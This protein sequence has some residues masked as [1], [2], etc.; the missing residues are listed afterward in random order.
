LFTKAISDG[1]SIFLPR[2]KE[3]V[4]ILMFPGKDGNWRVFTHDDEE[5][6]LL[7][8][9]ESALTAA[10]FILRDYF[11]LVTSVDLHTSKTF[12]Y[13]KIDYHIVKYDAQSIS[14]PDG[15]DGFAAMVADGYQIELLG[16]HP[17]SPKIK[18]AL[19]A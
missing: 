10:R 1:I 4:L 13:K 19:G 12:E 8:K 17:L 7:E 18:K 2:A 3:R 14:N 15:S 11:K 16:D 9:R 5:K 6:F